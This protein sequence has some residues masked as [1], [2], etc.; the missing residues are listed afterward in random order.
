MTAYSPRYEAALTLAAQA[1]R[2]QV[3]K[4]G[5]EPYI[6]HPVHA[7]TIL[8]RHGFSEDVVIAGLLHD[9]VE[10]AGVPL[11]RVEAEFGPTVAAIVAA[12]TE[13][14]LED[15]TVRPWEIRKQESLVQVRGASLE[16]VAVKA[17][18]ALH[19]ARSLARGLDQQGS[20]IWKHFSRGPE[21]T[22]GYYRGVTALVKER[23]G[24]HPL[25]IELDAAVRDLERAIADRVHN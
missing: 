7:S 2:D 15:G 9:V 19:S 17:A 11:A 14:R 22:L 20:S 25:A 21:V 18:D 12:V 10:D 16:A 6:V 13:R 3:R 24:H 23:L 8:L 5:D 4:T 1:H